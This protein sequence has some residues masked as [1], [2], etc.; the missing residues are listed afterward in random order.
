MAGRHVAM[1]TETQVNNRSP[2]PHHLHLRSLKS[3]TPLIASNLHTDWSLYH[4]SLH[5][6]SMVSTAV[7]VD[8]YSKYFFKI[9]LRSTL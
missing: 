4:V 6:S 2:Q 7:G 3:S 5:A 8:Q 9:F 1:A